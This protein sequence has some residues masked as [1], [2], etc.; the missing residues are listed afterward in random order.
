MWSFKIGVFFSQTEDLFELV[1]WA[2]DQAADID[3]DDL[4]LY[5]GENRN[6]DLKWLNVR[7]CRGLAF[8]ESSSCGW[9]VTRRAC[10]AVM[11]SCPSRN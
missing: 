7:Y 3:E 1:Q 4:E 6:M 5:Q 9:P 2:E 11:D 8:K 10:G